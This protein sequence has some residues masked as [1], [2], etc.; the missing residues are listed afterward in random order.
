MLI[1]S[2]FLLYL[3]TVLI[4]VIINCYRF[5]QNF[6]Q[7]EKTGSSHYFIVS[8]QAQLKNSKDFSQYQL[9][10]GLAPTDEHTGQLWFMNIRSGDESLECGER[11]CQFF[12]ADND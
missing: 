6:D 2:A 5:F 4:L 1:Q 12:N 3:F 10:V 11:N 9:R 7:H 8:T